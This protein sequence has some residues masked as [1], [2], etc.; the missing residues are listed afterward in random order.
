MKKHWYFIWVVFFFPIF[1]YG[2]TGFYSADS[3][4]STGIKLIDGGELINSKYC[5]IQKGNDIIQFSPLE[6][7]EYGFNSGSNYKSFQLNIN[8]TTSHYFLERLS[9]GKIKLYYLKSESG[10]IFFYLTVKDSANLKEVPELKEKYIELFKNLVGDCPQAIQNIPY[11]KFNKYNLQRF[12]QD[13]NNCSDQPLP[14]LRYGFSLGISFT[15][16]IPANGGI[17][18]NYTTKHNNDCSFLIGAFIDIPIHTNNFSFHPEIYYQQNRFSASFD[19]VT[20][21]N[22]LILDYSKISFPLLF[23]Y[24]IIDKIKTP[25]FQLGPVYSHILKNEN[26]W[27]IFKDDGSS[28]FSPK[29][30]DLTSTYKKVIVTDISNSTIM[31]NNLCGFSVAGGIIINYGSKYSWFSEFSYSKLFNLSMKNNLL[32]LREISLKMGFIF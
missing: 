1:I 4:I 12:F 25:Y 7:N 11:T 13:Y 9:D 29:D 24:S 10:K 2:Q 14:R 26:T 6:V 5:Q 20:N 23:R 21:F 31:Q 16:L 22:D 32:D 27:Y 30:D 28:Q 8:D 18:Y 17:F 15:Q 3:I 19:N